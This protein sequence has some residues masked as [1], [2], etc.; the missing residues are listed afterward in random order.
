MKHAVVVCICLFLVATVPASAQETTGA[1]QGNVADEVGTPIAG[2]AVEASGPPGKVVATSDS[3]GRYRFPRLAPGTYTVAA[4]FEG[5]PRVEAEAVRVILGEAVTIDF[6]LH[7]GTFEDEIQVYSETVVIDFTKNQTSTSIRQ[8]EIDYLP[9]GRD[10]TEVVTFAAGAIFDSQGGG[11]MIDGATGLENRF[12]IDG[13]NTTD[14]E[15]GESSVPMRAEFM[16]EVQVKSAGYTAEYGGAIGGV[17]NAV[18]RSGSN[19]FHGG[20]FV[21]IENNSWNGSARPQLENSPCTRCELDDGTTESVT[22]DKDDEIRYDP[23][24]FLGGPILRDRL[25]FFTSYQPGLRTTNRTIDWV[26]YPPDTYRQDYRID[27]ATANLT[28]NI[29]SRLLLKAG[30]N[31][32]PYTLDGFLPD[33][34][35]REDV[36]GQEEWA[37]LGTEGER[38]TYYL[39]AD[40]IATNNFVLSARGGFY[41]TNMVDTGIPFYDVIHNYSTRSIPGY[42]ERYPEIPADAQHDP[43]WYSN[44][45]VTGVDA[46]NIYERMT[47]NIDARRLF[48][49]PGDH[50]LKFGYQAEETY[51]NMKQGYNADRILY[52]WDRTY[53]TSEAES[54]KGAY[55]YFRLLN[56]SFLGEISVRNDAIFVQDAWTV[57]PNLTLNIGLRSEHEQL[58]N[59]GATG[60]DPAIEFGW[61]E[62]LA[63]RLGFAWDIVGN[64]KWKLYGS[65]G[66][67]YDVTKYLMPIFYFGGGKWVDFFYTFDTPDPFLNDVSTCRTGSNTIFERPECP[68]GTLIEARDRFPN[69]ADPAVW[70]MLGYPF[71]DPDLKPM[72]SWEAQLGLDH[73]LTATIQLGAR[74]VHKELVRTTEDVGILEFP[75]AGRF[76]AIGNPGEGTTSAGNGYPYPTPVRQY[77]ALELTFDKRFS[78]NWSLR[79]Y[80][81]LSRLWGNFSGLVSSDEQ[82]GYGDPL[83][84]SA[85]VRRSPNV[86]TMFDWPNI[87]YDANAEPVHGRLATDRTHQLRA[88]LLYSFN[89]GL[90]VGVTQYV[91]SGTPRSEIADI[92]SPN[93]GFFPNGRENLGET[94]WLTQTDLSL[95]QQFNFGR[96]GFSIGLT[97]LNLFDEDTAVRYRGWRALD[98]LPITTDEFFQGFDYESLVQTL[99]PDPSFNMADK[100]QL[101]RDIR[102]TFKLEF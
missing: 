34:D 22:W 66:R 23:G 24:F 8:R 15:I 55:G 9:R 96:L 89:F 28:S 36:P 74:F 68:A 20:V 78:D 101:P 16:E 85:S 43:G 72:E 14:P 67:Y 19:E 52:Y 86:S 33:R 70:E 77:D 60:P 99:K 48:T 73:Q 87:M 12:V 75:G 102:L 2:A 30:L 18:T 17:I 91:G 57:L 26:S 61:G 82:E 35:G 49:A 40:W 4:S 93:T 21:D 10:F 83:D 53:I 29:G 32:A 81:T 7:R 25:W 94:P 92:A 95:W 80:Y 64:A 31:L 51:H 39:T 37:P 76:Y 100:F 13:I 1:L 58:P 62:K 71:I 47:A 6:T 84:P 38:E 97:V 90:S 88:Q 63:P 59:Y 54:V 50:S 46:K 41:H 42:L 56:Q 5:L 69:V 44:N 65:W 27:F 45:L 98:P 3:A 11:I 79:A